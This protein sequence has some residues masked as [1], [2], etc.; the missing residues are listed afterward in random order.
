MDSR[1]IHQ[2]IGRPCSGGAAGGACRGAVCKRCVQALL[3][4]T[5]WHAALAR[6]QHRPALLQ[7]RGPHRQ[8]EAEAPHLEL[9]QLLGLAERE[10][11]HARQDE[12]Q[13]HQ[14]RPRHQPEGLRASGGGRAAAASTPSRVWRISRAVLPAARACGHGLAAPQR[15]R[16]APSS[17]KRASRCRQSPGPPARPGGRKNRGRR[18]C[19]FVCWEAKCSALLVCWW[20]CHPESRQQRGA[21]CP[22]AMPPNPPHLALVL[23]GRRR[24]RLLGGRGPR[25]GPR[26]GPAPAALGVRGRR[27]AARRVRRHTH[28]GAPPQLRLDRRPRRRRRRRRSSGS[29]LE[30]RCRAA[31]VRG[32]GGRHN[33]VPRHAVLQHRLLAGGGAAGAHVACGRGAGGLLVAGCRAPSH[34]AA[35]SLHWRSRAQDAIGTPRLQQRSAA[36]KRQPTNGRAQLRAQRRGGA[37]GPLGRGQRGRQV[38]VLP[39]VQVCRR[40][41]LHAQRQRGHVELRCGA[42]RQRARRAGLLCRGRRRGERRRR[43]LRALRLLLRALL[44]QQLLRK[45]LHHGQHTGGLGHVRVQACRGAGAAVRGAGRRRRIPRCRL[46]A[47]LARFATQAA[48]G[49][50]SPP[51]THLRCL[52]GNAAGVWRCHWLREPRTCRRRRRRRLEAER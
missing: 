28:H 51:R 31:R 5:A 1:P 10:V 24:R 7:R 26:R 40:H 43:L 50:T 22:P 27:R 52:C 39:P 2:M 6:L 35:S 45:R 17:C 48:R 34:S 21:P 33:Q 18:L 41:L 4:I 23:G 29:R 30:C 32:G 13:R 14:Q 49:S 38:P 44:V 25:R 9:A 15:Y 46:P 16:P 47:Q 42:R 36:S 37:A 11:Q 20:E 12:H 19:V 8:E 3:A